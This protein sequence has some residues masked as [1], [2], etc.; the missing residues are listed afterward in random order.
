MPGAYFT[1]AHDVYLNP[2][3]QSKDACGLEQSTAFWYVGGTDD[4]DS[5]NMQD[6]VM[7]ITVAAFHGKAVYDENALSLF[8]R[9]NSKD[10]QAGDELL[11]YA[12][13]QAK[14]KKANRILTVAM[15]SPK[16]RAKQ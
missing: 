12:E 4:K 5:V 6:K 3:Q 10:I 1:G 2:P 8:V 13:K 9:T 7:K 14:S 11:V 16:K 15:V